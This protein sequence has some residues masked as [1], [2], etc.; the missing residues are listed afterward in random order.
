MAIDS[1]NPALS[2]SAHRMSLA[3]LDRSWFKKENMTQFKSV[4]K[5]RNLETSEDTAGRNVLSPSGL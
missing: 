1:N 2:Q 3:N 4:R 5:K